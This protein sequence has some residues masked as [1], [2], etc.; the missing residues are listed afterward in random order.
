MNEHRIHLRR[1]WTGQFDAG[2]RRVDLPVVWDPGSVPI[3]LRRGFQRPKLDGSL[4]NL[5]L[6]FHA[7]KGVIAATLNGQRLTIAAEEMFECRV[8]ELLRASV[9]E[10]N[11]EL[12]AARVPLGESWGRV[13]LVIRAI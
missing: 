13:A 5:Y 11:L 12:D 8:D 6:E 9:N 4:E 2:E 1:A 3:A 7:I 10:L